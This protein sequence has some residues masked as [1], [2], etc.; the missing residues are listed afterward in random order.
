MQNS[1]AGFKSTER[2]GATS[3]GLTYLWEVAQ[4]PV[5]VRVDLQ[6]VTRLDRKVIQA[7]RPGYDGAEIGGLLLGTVTGGSPILVTLDDYELIPCDYAF[8]PLF[9]LTT[10]DRIR[11]A[12]RV[13]ERSATGGLHVVGFFRSHTRKGLALDADDVKFCA[14]QF[15]HP[16]QVALLIRPEEREVS[17]AGV[18][19]WEDGSIR[20]EASYLE[21]PFSHDELLK[22]GL[23]GSAKRG[24][25]AQEPVTAAAPAAEVVAMQE[26]AKR[27]HIVPICP[28]RE[29]GTEP[30]IPAPPAD[31]N[32]ISGAEWLPGR[33]GRCCVKV[34][35]RPSAFRTSEENDRR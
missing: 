4:R 11:F 5:S 17:T 7:V 8:G 13:A 29:V 14:A 34:Q 27:G 21:F 32:G 2:V 16:Y 26:P 15:G 12:R 1:T 33:V 19:I 6:M 35:L 23:T 25:P 3:A 30:V 18:F 10:R 31:S 20:S 24:V 9:Q 22:R 28:R